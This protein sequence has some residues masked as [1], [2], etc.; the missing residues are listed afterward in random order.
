MHHE[1]RTKCS[2]LARVLLRV[3]AFA[4]P[5]ENI[6]ERRTADSCVEGETEGLDVDPLASVIK[7]ALITNVGGAGYYDNVVDMED[8]E[9]MECPDFDAACIKEVCKYCN[10]A[11]KFLYEP[12]QV[13]R[14][15]LGLTVDEVVVQ[16]R[17]HIA[18]YF[19]RQSDETWFVGVP[20]V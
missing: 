15:T 4:F 5:A 1:Q 3:N 6:R 11:K 14:D 19:I 7:N 17:C 2:N 20:F 8:G 9:N 12:L 18:M 13:V 16:C 10:S